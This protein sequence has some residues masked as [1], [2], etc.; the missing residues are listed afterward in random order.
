MFRQAS[1]VA[2]V[3]LTALGSLAVAAAQ[4]PKEA[5]G[6]TKSPPKEVA[7]DLGWRGETGDGLDSRGRVHDGLARCGQGRHRDEK[8]QHRVR[9]TKPFYLGKYLVTQEQWRP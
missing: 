2:L 6:K 4:Q 3:V 7:V 1:T 5:G 8:P 9:I